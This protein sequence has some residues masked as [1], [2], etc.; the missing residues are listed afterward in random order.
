MAD[1]ED[2]SSQV[3]NVDDDSLESIFKNGLKSELRALVRMLKPKGIDELVATTLEM[4][5][6][7]LSRMVGGALLQEKGGYRNRNIMLSQTDGGWK[8]RQHSGNLNNNSAKNWN[9][10]TSLSDSKGQRPRLKLTPAEYEEKKRKGL[11][12]KCDEKY[13]M[14]HQCLNKELRVLLV[15]N[16]CEIELEEDGEES[17]EEE[18]WK[19]SRKN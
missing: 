6:S 14:G 3:Y 16:G 11:C 15:V 8:S 17:V 12:F 18:K 10:N 2:L 7:V 4:E 1:F 5:A 9:K 13:F 19:K